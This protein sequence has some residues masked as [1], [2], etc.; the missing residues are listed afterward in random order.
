MF[1]LFVGLCLFVICVGVRWFAWR[2]SV[3]VVIPRNYDDRKER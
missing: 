2:Y 1:W 3:C